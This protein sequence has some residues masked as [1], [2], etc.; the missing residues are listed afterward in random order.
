M[1]KM[2][3][4]VLQYS[5][6]NVAELL[7]DS[8]IDLFIT[9]GVPLPNPGQTPPLTDLQISQ[10]IGQG[11]TVV[12]YVDVA[13]T[14]ANRSYWNPSWTSNGDDLGIPTASA[15]S[16]LQNQ[17]V[18]AFGHIVKFWDTAWQAIVIN[19]AVDLVRRGYS[20]VFLDDVGQYYALG[21][22]G[23]E[24]QIRENADR[25]AEFVS[26]I[27]AAVRRVNPNA[28]VV[29]NAD[30]YL[31]TNVTQDARGADDAGK[32]LAAVDAQL[33]EN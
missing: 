4:Y 26:A 3:S 13:V 22:P 27:A 33:L 24:T 30:P 23:G 29:A 16:W 8:S 5:N 25:M 2:S 12:G 6:V 28:Y 9:E 10:L 15:P 31:V 17:P 14:D 19:Q 1:V 11:R 7:A 18:N 20:G 32:Y 21:E